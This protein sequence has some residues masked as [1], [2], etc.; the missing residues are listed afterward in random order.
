MQPTQKIFRLEGA[1]QHYNWGGERFLPNLLGKINTDHSPFAEYWMGAHENAPSILILPD[2]TKQ[3]L[4]DFIRKYDITVLGERVAAKFGRLPY[5]FKILDV[6]DM[7]S[8]QVHPSKNAAELEFAEENK[9]NIPLKASNRN[10]KDDNHKPELMVAW[11]DF[12]LLHGFKPAPKLKKIVNTVPELLFLIPAWKQSG[13]EGV[14]KLVMEM[15]QAE[16]NKI[17]QPMVDR[18]LPLYENGQL[19]KSEED[20]WAARA[21]NTFCKE[22]YI[23]RGLFSVYLFN[24]VKLQPGEAIFQDAGILHAY[25]EGQNLE[26]MANSDNVLRGG[27][28]TKQIDVPELLRHV[29]FVP[30]EPAII[31]A[32]RNPANGEEIFQTP[33][34]DFELRRLIL[35]KS[36]AVK[37]KSNTIDIFL[38]ADG[39]VEAIENDTRINLSKG[40]SMLAINGASLT[41]KPGEMG[42]VVFRAT[43]PGE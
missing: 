22:G 37:L 4:D 24:L 17:L 36:H 12:W 29:K 6:K 16:V 39:S 41:I 35:N 30:V 40:Q 13:Y 18:I 8:I 25:L 42:A 21:Y 38:V 7:L 14:Y 43:V 33:A 26:L 32:K 11:S 9:K 5:L 1:I 2:G 28:T 3:S 10:Y 23:D 34:A 15:D 31:T 19:N 20:F 27:L